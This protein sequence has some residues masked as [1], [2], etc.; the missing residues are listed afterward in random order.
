MTRSHPRKRSS[1]SSAE[2]Q[3]RTPLAWAV[4]CGSMR[5]ATSATT[6]I[7]KANVQ[8]VAHGGQATVDV[9]RKPVQYPNVQAAVRSACPRW[10]LKA[11]TTAADAGVTTSP[12]YGQLV[13]FSPSGFMFSHFFIHVGIAK[14]AALIVF[15]VIQIFQPNKKAGRPQLNNPVLSEARAASRSPASRSPASPSPASPS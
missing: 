14:G 13:A 7:D 6:A 12:H 8:L 15:R 3:Q 11:R 10:L 4:S 5:C 1:S 2:A 9:T